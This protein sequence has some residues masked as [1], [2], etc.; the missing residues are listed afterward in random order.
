M[1]GHNGFSS[2]PGRES[3]DWTA[4][5]HTAG[6]Y[7]NSGTD[8]NVYTQDN[9]CV[10]GIDF[11]WTVDVEYPGGIHQ[12]P[13][14]KH[15]KPDFIPVG[16]G[17]GNGLAGVI[18]GHWPH[19]GALYHQSRFE[20]STGSDSG[21]DPVDHFFKR[22]DRF[23]KPHQDRGSHNP[24]GYVCYGLGYGDI[25]WLYP[26]VYSLCYICRNTVG[27]TADGHADGVWNCK[28]Y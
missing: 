20:R 26:G 21:Q 19:F 22:N 16:E 2:Y 24:S 23:C 14:G 12:Q 27:R 28:R 8:I 11:L 15:T 10:F 3:F 6:Y 7:P 13:P 17:Y 18:T 4:D 5:Q 1:G 25:N 9:R